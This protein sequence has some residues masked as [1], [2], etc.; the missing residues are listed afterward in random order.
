[1]TFEEKYSILDSILFCKKF[2]FIDIDYIEFL[3]ALILSDN[4][5]DYLNISDYKMRKLTR[6]LVPNKS[7]GRL[8]NYILLSSGM[9]YCRH[10]DSYLFV[11]DFRYNKSNIDGIN[12]YCMACHSETTAVT[13]PHRQAAYNAAKNQRTPP[14]ADLK[15]IKEIYDNCPEGYHVDHIVPL[16]GKL[17]SGLH[18]ETNLQYLPAIENI[19]KGNKFNSCSI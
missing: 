2:L 4:V 6:A 5:T 18:I 15:K 12:S 8:I 17:V 13:Q 16:N 11:E 3:T 9:K 10:C 1:M 14:W 19:K 7:K